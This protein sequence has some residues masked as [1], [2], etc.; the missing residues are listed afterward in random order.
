[1]LRPWCSSS[2]TAF[3]LSLVATAATVTGCGDEMEPP[4]EELGEADSLRLGRVHVVLEPGDR[5]ADDDQLEVTARFAFVRG[6]DEDF[7]R[8]RI[9][10]PLLAHEILK[11]GQCTADDLTTVGDAAPESALAEP[12]ELVLVD[13]GDLRLHAGDSSIR[14]P[15]SLVPDLLP[16][17]SGV[18]YVYDG[19]ALPASDT[20]GQ[21]PLLIE[22][23]GSPADEL[24]PFSIEG[25]IPEEI[26]L[27]FH[28]EDLYELDR[29]A[30]VLRWRPGGE[31]GEG[32]MTLRMVPLMGGEPA[33]DEITCVFEDV[34]QTRVDLQVLHTLGLPHGAEAVR[35]SASRSVI[36][37]F[38][39][40]MFTGSELIVERRAYASVPLD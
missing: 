29:D 35:V 37:G 26:G 18:E 4:V 27:T 8:A 34:G 36:T 7:V 24:P 10:M 15:M 12:R 16:Y 38:D 3:A 6:L 14:I 11:P 20:E 22:G 28:E 5:A 17:M 21:M 30:L 13:A 33:G 25:T 1:M 2:A 9:D 19:A 23:E 32:L 31:Y 39:A 40:G